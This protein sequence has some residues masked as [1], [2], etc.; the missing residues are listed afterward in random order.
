MAVDTEQFYGPQADA[1]YESTKV[2]GASTVRI[3]VAWSAVAPA[4]RSKPAGFDAGNPADP[5]YNWSAVDAAIRGAGH[6]GLAVV[7]GLVGAPAWAEGTDRPPPSSAQ[8][9]DV[10]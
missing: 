9:Q 10:H 5:H 3:H 7:A 4:G 2:A 6:H 8:G 1:A